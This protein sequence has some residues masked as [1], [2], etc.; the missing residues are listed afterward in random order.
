MTC[1]EPMG[2]EALKRTLVRIPDLHWLKTSPM[3]SFLFCTCEQTT[4]SHHPTQL[5]H[6][7]PLHRHFSIHLDLLMSSWRTRQYVFQKLGTDKATYFLLAHVMRIIRRAWVR[8]VR[9]RHAVYHTHAAGM[10]RN[11]STLQHSSCG[12]HLKNHTTR[13]LVTTCVSASVSYIPYILES[14]P[15][16]F[17]SFRG[18]KNQMRITIACGLDSRS[19]A[20]FC[21][22][23]GAAVRAVRTTQYNNLLFYLLLI[24]IYY[25]S[26]SPS[27]LITESLSVLRRDCARLLRKAYFKV[28][29][30]H[31]PQA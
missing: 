2:V 13:L 24:I 26:D 12:R 23:D 31:Q 16:P 10:G 5:T 14:N 8:L 1:P 20:E 7:L 21:K 27:S 30:T 19:R 6:F 25:S 17:Y 3:A 4:L 28:L 29:M 9:M 22:N 11:C 15:H 18:L